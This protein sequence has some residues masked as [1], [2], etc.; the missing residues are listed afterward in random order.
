MGYR[1]F[2]EKTTFDDANDSTAFTV[3]A[4]EAD[5]DP[6]VRALS[7]SV[8]TLLEKGDTLGAQRRKSR[9]A[10]IRANARVRTA[11]GSADDALRE[12]DKDLLAEVRQNRND[13]FYQAVYA[14]ETMSAM[15]DLTLA[16]EVEDLERVVAVLKGKDAPVDLRKTWVPRFEKVI[17]K[18][19]SALDERKKAT[20]LAAETAAN[21]QRWIERLDRTRRALDGALTTYAAKQG[22]PRDFNGRFFPAASSTGRKTKA[23]PAPSDVAPSTP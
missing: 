1:A 7:Q 22:K 20:Q 19:R 2:S 12:F 16:P 9:R 13:P 4:L 18:G 5:D 14:G 23:A 8:S 15:I 11:D 6:H 17:E 10:M 21:I 3:E